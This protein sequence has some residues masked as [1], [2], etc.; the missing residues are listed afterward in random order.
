MKKLILLTAFLIS[1]SQFCF[2]QIE[3]T[4]ELMEF[5]SSELQVTGDTP[6]AI[7]IHSADDRAV[8][9]KNSIVYY[10][11]LVKNGVEAEMHLYPYG[12]HGYSLAIGRGHLAGWPERA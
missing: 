10:E 1:V 7:L 9:V 6:P 8:P 5:Y 3:P 11:A 4:R 2:A 12:G